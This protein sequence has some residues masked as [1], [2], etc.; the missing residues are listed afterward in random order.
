MQKHLAGC[1]GD[2]HGDWG[3]HGCI[4]KEGGRQYVSTTKDIGGKL[5]SSDK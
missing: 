1:Y 4:G 5:L 2:V 3:F